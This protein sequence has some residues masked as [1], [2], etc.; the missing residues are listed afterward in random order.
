MVTIKRYANRKLYDTQAGRYVTLEEIGEMVRRGDDL[1]VVD[2]ASGGDLTTLTLLQ[3]VLEDEKSARAWLPHHLLARLI[4]AG[5]ARFSSLRDAVFSSLE[6]HDL[7]ERE[8]ER[9]IE[10]LAKQ[11]RLAPEETERLK[12]LLLDPDLAQ[13]EPPTPPTSPVS[14]AEI[15]ALIARIDR[16]NA[17]VDELTNPGG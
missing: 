6:Q 1:R 17:T 12:S 2:H 9:R 11:S 10:L 14:S 13:A 5:E 8:I 3:V 16:L 15:Q 4:R 7:V